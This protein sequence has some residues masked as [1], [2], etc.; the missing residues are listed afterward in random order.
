MTKKIR[1]QIVSGKVSMEFQ[2][3][4]G[5]HYRKNTFTFLNNVLSLFP[6]RFLDYLS[7]LCVSNNVAIAVTQELICK[8]VLDEKNGDILIETRIVRTPVEL[9]FELE[10]PVGGGHAPVAPV[11]Q[12]SM[13]CE[14]FSLSSLFHLAHSITS[15]VHRIY[16]TTL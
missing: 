8:A 7:D 5:C 1:F 12:S 16:C 9:E 6:K 15:T 3:A 2:I 10:V 4:G 13:L 14:A 11:P